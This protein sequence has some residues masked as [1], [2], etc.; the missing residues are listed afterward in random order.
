MLNFKAGC[1]T[2]RNFLL[3]ISITVAGT[4]WRGVELRRPRFPLY[5]RVPVS[6][7]AVGVYLLRAALVVGQ[8]TRRIAESQLD[9][10]AESRH[11]P[12]RR[13]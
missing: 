9:G 4:V 7:R 8:G 2:N 10:S 6:H 3:F 5:R 11:W 13:R 12:L 1:D